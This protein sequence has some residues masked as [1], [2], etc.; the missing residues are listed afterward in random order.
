MRYTHEQTQ[1]KRQKD[2]TRLCDEIVSTGTAIAD[3]YEDYIK[4]LHALA[5][6]TSHD[7]KENF[8]K[9]AI[10]CGVSEKRA[11]KMWNK[12][13]HKNHKSNIETFFYMCK[14][15]G[16][17]INTPAE[18]TSQ[19]KKDFVKATKLNTQ[20][21]KNGNFTLWV[22]FTENTKY[23]YLIKETG[24]EIKNNRHSFYS[25]KIGE[26]EPSPREVIN[27]FFDKIERYQQEGTLHKA[28]IYLNLNKGNQIQNAKN[29]LVHDY[30]PRRQ[31]ERE[32]ARATA[33]SMPQLAM[34]KYASQ[35]EIETYFFEL[36]EL[37][38]KQK[39]N[40]G[41]AQATKDYIYAYLQQ[42]PPTTAH[43]LHTQR[44][45]RETRQAS[46]VETQTTHQYATHS[47]QTQNK[48]QRDEN[49]THHQTEYKS[50]AQKRQELREARKPAQPLPTLTHDQKIQNYTTQLY[51]LSDTDCIDFFGHSDRQTLINEYK[52]QLEN[53]F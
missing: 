28:H 26:P 32:K 16:L 50:H 38:H 3:N 25:K 40:K 19:E 9:I 29:I 37:E 35:T 8:V 13:A 15:A 11:L 53:E 22:C 6:D 39:I 18:H 4:I 20:W 45:E 14:N 34:H 51:A 46:E 48:N 52:K 23:E 36:Q 43:R 31:G 30:K 33:E 49:K 1:Q 17:D 12:Q 44:A 10:V 42:T 41:Q 2:I 21:D 5:S 24:E 7:H 27:F 47:T